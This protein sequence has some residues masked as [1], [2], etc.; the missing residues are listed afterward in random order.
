MQNAKVFDD[1]GTFLF[2]YSGDTPKIGDTLNDYTVIGV[3]AD[4]IVVE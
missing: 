4:E 1:S 2:Y 3:D